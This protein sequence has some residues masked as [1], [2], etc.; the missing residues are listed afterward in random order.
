MKES[1]L[2][3]IELAAK[4][5]AITQS[6]ISHILVDRNVTMDDAFKEWMEWLNSRSGSHNTI[7]TYRLR[8]KRWLDDC[9]LHNAQPSSITEED[10][11][12]W[13]NREC[14]ASLQTRNLDMVAIKMFWKF[15]V[16]K[17]YSV[18][19][20]SAFVTIHWQNLTQEQRTHRITEIYTDSE[21]AK[22]KAAAD[23]NDSDRFTPG[24]W[25][26]AV[27]IARRLGLRISDICTLEWSSF[28]VEGK[29]KINTRKRNIMVE[30]ELN[31]PE[32]AEALRLFKNEHSVYVWP[33]ERQMVIGSVYR[34]ILS[35]EYRR[36]MRNIGLKGKTFHGL[37]HT[38]ATELRN[39]GKDL[40][41]I[42]RSLGHQSFFTTMGYLH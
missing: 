4:A 28:A 31:H 34:G 40:P 36:M 41:H 2:E 18:A 32:I 21:Y 12:Y 30:L 26:A 39:A 11:S 35:S 33:L 5:N 10:I 29:V 17:G 38:F 23:S 25:G 19:N 13:V 6:S 16:A 37:R 24:F 42:A 3:K 27:R 22:A 8:V 15:V 1:K 20:P 14:G 9:K 7:E